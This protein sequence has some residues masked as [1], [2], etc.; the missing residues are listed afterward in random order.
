MR[1]KYFVI[2][3]LMSVVTKAQL[4]WE[5]NF[6]TDKDSIKITYDATQGNGALVNVFPVYF[7]TGVIT[8]QSTSPTD[9][10][11][12]V[13]EWGSSNSKYQMD[14]L[15]NN[16]WQLKIQNIRQY[17]GVPEGEEIL[18]LAFVF[19][20]SDGTKVGR[21][22]D[23]SDMFIPLSKAGLN[24]AIVEPSEEPL[25]L[26]LG[27]SLHILAV[28]QASSNLYLYLDDSLLTSTT[29]D[30]IEATVTANSY[31]K[32]RII[33]VAKDS[34]GNQAAD[35]TY[36]V[37]HGQPPV[38]ALPAGIEDGIN[39]IDNSTVTLSLFAPKKKFVYVIGDFNNWEVDPAFEMKKTPDGEHYWL[40]ISNLKPKV[41]YAFQYFVDAKIRI[42]DPYCDK[43]LDPWNDKYIDSL[44]Y[45]HLKPYPLG[46]TNEAVSV[47]ETGQEPFNWTD[48]DFKRPPKSKLVVYELLIRDFLKDHNYQTLTDTLDYFKRLGVNAIELMPIMEFEGNLSWGYNTSFLFAPDKY[49]GTKK[50]LKTFVNE[51][52]KKGIAV[53]LDIVLDHAFGQSPFVR[54]YSLGRYGPPSADNPWLNPDMNPNKAGYQGP[55][56]YGVGYDFNHESKYTQALVDRVNRYWIKEFHADGYRYDLSKGFTQTYSGDDVNKWGEYDAS[57]IAILKRMADKLWAFDPKAYIILEHFAVNSEETVLAN[58]GMMLWGNLNHEYLEAAMGYSSNLTWCSY[59]ARNW[60]DPNL[61]AYMESHDEERMMY[62]NLKWGNSSG[63]Y[64]IKSLNTALDRVKLASAFFFTIPGPKMMWQFEEL[65][66]DYSIDYNGRTGEKPIRWDYYQDPDRSRLF[67]TVAAIIKLKNYAAFNTRNF[68][69]SVGGYAKRIN[70]YDSTMNVVVIG[71]FK[72]TSQ[73][74]NPNFPSAG[75]WYDYLDGDSISVSDAS[76]SVTLSPGEYH[77]YTSVRLPK[78]DIGGT[79][80]VEKSSN[81]LPASFTL[82][83]NYPNPFP[84]SDGTGNPTTTIKYS[85]PSV[86]SNPS[87]A[88]GEKSHR[89]SSQSKWGRNNNTNVTLKV[90]DVLGREVATLVNK[91]QKP[92]NYSVKFNANNLTSGVYFYRLKAGNFSE[93]RKMVLIR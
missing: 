3:L 72:V 27:A 46:K 33:A 62:K 41:E 29:S 70:L 87:E 26:E 5:P 48:S 6:V 8:D 18:K 24:V 10:R 30:T 39:Y 86:I 38:E 52:H 49:Y 80:S 66:Y 63:S 53:I 51:A 64:N 84:A 61:V 9:W 36:Y 81:N 57:R 90:Y 76:A 12:V 79:S 19:R 50:A 54:L 2:I 91:A 83:Q 55:H 44:T 68:S 32:R 43:I 77:I 21:A 65:G 7:H 73:S 74:I 67:K 82:S 59:K 15:G 20:N 92:G 37:V 45:P 78:P 58:Y 25:F 4:T 60:K 69:M 75:K 34:Q 22:S 35:S 13:T 31:G 11:Y 16:K 71:N 17:Y 14:Y 40:T 28:S 23:G 89:I 42:A 56:P 47:L 1:L 85:I 88:S 93:V